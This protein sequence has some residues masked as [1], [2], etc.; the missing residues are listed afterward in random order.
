MLK[1]ILLTTLL[2]LLLGLSLS[3]NSEPTSE[4]VNIDNNKDIYFSLN[5]SNNGLTMKSFNPSSASSTSLVG[6]QWKILCFDDDYN[7]LLEESGTINSESEILKLS[8][9]QGKVYRFLFLCSSNT[10]LLPTLNAGDNYWNLDL[11]SPQLPLTNPMDMLTSV[12]A[13]DGT[14]RVA[15]SAS[16]L[17]VTLLPRVAKILVQ[18]DVENIKTG[19]IT[20]SNVAKSAPYFNIEPRYY[21]D[22]EQISSIKKTNYQLVYQGEGAYYILPD[23][24]Q[25][26]SPAVAGTI[27]VTDAILGEQ[28]IPILLPKGLTLNV[29]GGKTYYIDIAKSKID[30]QLSATWATRVIPKTLTVATQNLWGKNAATVIDYFNKINVDVLCTQEASGFNDYEISSAGLYVH[31]HTN[32]GQGRCSII[33]RHPFVGVTPNKYGVYIDL[34]DNITALVMNCHGEWKPYGPYQLSGIPYQGFPATT[35]VEEVIKMNYD[36]RIDMVN[37]LLEDVLS[38]TTPFISV[39]GDYNEPSWLDWTEAAVEAKHVTHVV[40]WPTTHEL[41]KGGVTGDAYRAIHPDPVAHPGITWTPF[42]SD[43]DT[44]DRIDLTLYVESPATTVLKSEVLGE[45]S[46]TSDI[47]ITPWVFDHRGVRSVFKYSR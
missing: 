46:E 40:P 15:A 1:N 34:G 21:D 10:T 2:T 47:V 33:S 30:G 4:I 16:H 13:E 23:L 19:S 12:G 29:S 36:A 14:M 18:T 8:L 35:N 37:K 11:Y 5:T 24:F 28:E 31:S 3:C 25:H 9:P 41:W 43:K 27:K 26:S 45:S 32:N 7:Y 42:P 39:S 44:K 20:L 22:Y 6:M 17:T 38:S